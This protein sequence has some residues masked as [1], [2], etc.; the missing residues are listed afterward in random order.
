MKGCVIRPW[1]LRSNYYFFYFFANMKKIACQDKYFKDF[2]SI[3]I[4]IKKK[5]KHING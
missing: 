5:N 1:K 3:Q 2:V 4:K